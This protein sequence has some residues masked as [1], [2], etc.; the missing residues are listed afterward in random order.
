[1]ASKCRNSL[2]CPPPLVPKAKESPANR[3]CAVCSSCPGF[4]VWPST[5]VLP[6][7][8]APPQFSFFR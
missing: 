4:V 3:S 7:A 8:P 5:P 1:M 2:A 6:A